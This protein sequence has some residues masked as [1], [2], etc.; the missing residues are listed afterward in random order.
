MA[1]D[2]KAKSVSV[3]F[4]ATKPLQILVCLML[5]RQL[6]LSG[7]A[8]LFVVDNFA[9]A[10]AVIDDLAKLRF[11]WRSVRRCGSR[12]QALDLA[13]RR[14]RKVFL[15]RDVGL[16]M[17]FAMLCQ[18]AAHGTEFAIYEEGVSSYDAVSELS[19]RQQLVLNLVGGATMLGR[20]RL[21][22]EFWLFKPG[23]VAL[24]LHHESKL[25]RIEGELQRFIRDERESLSQL[26]WRGSPIEHPS[27]PECHLYLPSWTPDT[28]TAMAVLEQQGDSFLK[29]HPHTR[30][31]HPVS[32]LGFKRVLPSV[33]PAELLLAELCDR[34]QVVHV[35]HH[36]SSVTRYYRSG[37]VRFHFVEEAA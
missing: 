19:R 37:Q 28:H 26:F 12:F 9:G 22:S 30:E 33:I 2:R 35:Y 1:G 3:A 20:S 31:G 4:L 18:K 27:E 32:T 25:R 13:S 36:G 29:L 23:D 11:G 34:Y 10:G 17:F 14:S 21:T 8:D 15:D 24:D 5:S 6:G 16:A 7:T